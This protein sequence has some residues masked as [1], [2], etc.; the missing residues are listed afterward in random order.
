M[1][2]APGA[3]L[4]P[5]LFVWTK[6]FVGASVTWLLLPVSMT[7]PIVKVAVLRFVSVTGC[8]GPML[9]IGWLAK[10]RLD[11]LTDTRVP[12]PVRFSTCGPPPSLSVT[13]IVP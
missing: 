2:L 1:Q 5:Q 9:P 11:G 8:E 6:F 10:A 13:V 4:P 12:T 3:K 7:P